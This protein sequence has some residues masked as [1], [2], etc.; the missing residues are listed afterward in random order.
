MSVSSLKFVRYLKS[1]AWVI[2][3]LF[4]LTFTIHYARGT[5]FENLT[6][7][8]KIAVKLNIEIQELPDMKFDNKENIKKINCRDSF[9]LV[10]Y[11][12]EFIGYATNANENSDENIATVNIFLKNTGAT[13]WYGEETACKNKI[14]LGTQNYQDRA[15]IFWSDVKDSNWAQNSDKNRITLT[16]KL[17]GPNEIAVF[18]FKIKIPEKDGI[19]REYFSP[20]IPG[21]GWMK[22]K[23]YLDFEIG[24]PLAEDREK[25]NIANLSVA[26]ND[27]IGEKNIEADLGSQMIY[28]RYGEVR[29]R[30]AQISSGKPS[31]PTPKANWTIHN[32]Q[33]LRVSSGSTPYKMPL[34]L[35]LKRGRYGFQGYGLHGL[36]YLE[37]ANGYRYWDEVNEPKMH[38]GMPVSHGCVRVEPGFDEIMWDFA[39]I[40]MAV[41]T[42]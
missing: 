3:G 7:Q 38:M 40:G 28:L 25:I 11:S 37:T 18:E 2:L 15:S 29:F 8:T 20:V 39:E 14:Q 33:K 16:Q 35:G 5:F 1:F 4:L 26:S 41:W 34:W 21:V 12:S 23:F 31:T 42:H 36:P 9:E 17:I 6:A 27:L 32:K 24:E 19:Y 22:E 13:L 10:D 30:E